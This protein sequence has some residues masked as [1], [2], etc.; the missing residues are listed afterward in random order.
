MSV[1][2]LDD[3]GLRPGTHMVEGEYSTSS[4]D[5]HTYTMICIMLSENS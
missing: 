5:L 4:F 2:K 3:L 1:V